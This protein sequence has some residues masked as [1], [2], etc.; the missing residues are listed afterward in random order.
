MIQ[1]KRAGI[2]RD[3]VDQNNMDDIGGMVLNVDG[4]FFHVENKTGGV[5][6][7]IYHRGDI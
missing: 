5:I 3:N 4:A 7:D 2:S 6:I 1:A